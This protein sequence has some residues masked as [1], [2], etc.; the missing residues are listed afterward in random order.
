MHI[1][2][3]LTILVWTWASLAS[4]HSP[5]LLKEQERKNKETKIYCSNL[6][7]FYPSLVFFFCG[8]SCSCD[9]ELKHKISGKF[10]LGQ[11]FPIFFDSWPLMKT[12]GFY[13]PTL[14]ENT[15]IKK[16]HKN[17]IYI[18]AQKRMFLWFYI[19]KKC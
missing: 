11:E 14:N 15:A 19:L 4:V 1:L 16:G 2:Y 5:A 7:D 8:G 13:G 12:D 9:I 18:L 6:L 17:L 10:S 3:N